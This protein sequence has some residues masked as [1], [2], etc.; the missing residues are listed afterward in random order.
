VLLY[1]RRLL[2][3]F[4]ERLHGYERKLAEIGGE[5]KRIKCAGLPQHVAKEAEALVKKY[6]EVVG[7]FPAEVAAV[8]VDSG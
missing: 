2:D 1:F 8:A 7:G 3:V 4:T 5:L 6:F